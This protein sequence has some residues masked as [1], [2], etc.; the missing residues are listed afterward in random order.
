MAGSGGQYV[1]SSVRPASSRRAHIPGC[2]RV[3]KAVSQRCTTPIATLTH[4]VL[5]APVLNRD[6]RCTTNIVASP[7]CSVTLVHIKARWA[8]HH[9]ILV[10]H[11]AWCEEACRT[12][13]RIEYTEKDVV[14]RH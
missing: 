5:H 8:L 3:C 12:V 2:S 10:V 9:N 4:S 13:L 14:S 11:V 6:E 7:D 1:H